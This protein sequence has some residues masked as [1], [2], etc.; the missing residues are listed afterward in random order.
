MGISYYIYLSD[1]RVS[2]LFGKESQGLSAKNNVI[3]REVVEG[4]EESCMGGSSFSFKLG[5]AK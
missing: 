3:P 4:G 1:I 2:Q 5:G